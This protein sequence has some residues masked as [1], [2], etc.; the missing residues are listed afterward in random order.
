M[1]VIEPLVARETRFAF[2]C[3]ANSLTAASMAEKE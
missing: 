1:S 3:P 2:A